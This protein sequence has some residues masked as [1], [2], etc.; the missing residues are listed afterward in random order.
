MCNSTRLGENWVETI[1]PYLPKDGF[2]LQIISFEKLNSNI[3][4]LE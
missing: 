3:D 1:L 4:K 2:K